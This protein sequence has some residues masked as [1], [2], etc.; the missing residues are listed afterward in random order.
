[1]DSNV[2][3]YKIDQK[4]KQY[5][6]TTS[7]Q[8]NSI[9]ISC[10][11]ELESENVHSRT[12]TLENLKKM[13]PIFDIIKTPLEA[14]EWIDKAVKLQRVRIVDDMSSFKIV[15]NITTNGISN[16]VEIPMSEQEN[17]SSNL[18]IATG[19]DL[20]LVQETKTVI[21]PITETDF[22]R[23]IGLDPSKVVRQTIN[24]DTAQIIKSIEDEER[25]SLS[26][27]NYKFDNIYKDSMPL[28]GET[29]DINAITTDNNEIQVANYQIQEETKNIIPEIATET[30]TKYEETN[31]D[32]N[33][34]TNIQNQDNTDNIAQ[35]SENTPDLN[36]QY[37][38]NQFNLEENKI[39]S[40]PEITT[41]YTENI[42][43]NNIFD[44][45]QVPFPATT[46]DIH[47]PFESKPYITP[48]DDNIEEINQITTTEVKAET[49]PFNINYDNIEQD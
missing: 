22:I 46:E 9:K 25:N 28:T 44:S 26:K 1:M 48:V 45:N 7:I 5:I 12:F 18:N 17:T 34:F 47:S 14:I 11:N 13:D 35:Y 19:T 23:E 40:I 24:E 32:I 10:K 43:S 33:Q 29:L 41:Q 36:T 4:D 21:K 37:F 42:Q 2:N 39:S 20:N 31:F 30:T 49:I 27:I 3:S 16:Q 8:E 38:S 15:F 6:L